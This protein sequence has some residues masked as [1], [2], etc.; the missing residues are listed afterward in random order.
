MEWQ[1]VEDYTYL[2]LPKSYKLY[3]FSTLK[4]N[5]MSEDRCAPDIE[6]GVFSIISA[7]SSPKDF[8]TNP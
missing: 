3:R 7:R 8:H 2:I 1:E 4:G 6:E 5:P